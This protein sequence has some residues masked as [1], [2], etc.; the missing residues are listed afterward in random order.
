MKL[1]TLLGGALAAAVLTGTASAELVIPTLDYRT[2]PYAPNGIPFANGYSDYFTLLNERDGGIEG[3]KIRLEPC[4]TAYNTQKGVEC[5]EKT[6]NVGSGALVYQPL[7][8][9]ITYQ[10]IPKVTEDRIPMHT[11]GYGRT[12]AA[13]GRIFEW[14]FNFPL[15]YWD[16]ATIAIQYIADQEGGFDRLRGKKIALVYHNSAYGKEPIRTLEVMAEKFGYKLLL[17]PVDHP[18]QEQKATWLQIRRERPDWVLMWGWGVMN[19]VAI[20]EAASIRY[21]MDR[22]IGVWWSGS[23]NDVLPSGMAANGYKSLA[24]HA[25]GADFP[26]HKDILK[27]VYDRGKAVDPGFRD[28]VG[29]VLYNR[30]LIAAVWAAEAIRTAMRIHGTKNVTA[31]MVRDGFEN[32]EVSEQRLAE[33]G[34]P[35]FTFGIKISCANHRGAGKAAV[36]QWDARAKKWKIVSKYYS[37]LE[38]VVWPL[39]EEDSMNYAKEHGITPR[40]CK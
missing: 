40:D 28:R 18:G 34:L 20:K 25:A 30:G 35:G 33:L 2:G 4:E 26:L 1:K 23:E 31:A 16:G 38:D 14:V 13:N 22:F 9:G 11:M 6:K 8:T 37:P 21:P 10:L 5:Y 24:F 7:S 29:E 36:Q 3:V 17:L 32:L 15:T 27:Y 19:Q 39:I 12:S